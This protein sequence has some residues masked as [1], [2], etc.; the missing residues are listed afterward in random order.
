MKVY[1]NT[2]IEGIAGWVFYDSMSDSRF[3]FNHIQ[4]MNLLLTNEVDAAAKACFDSGAD[5]VYINDSHGCAYNII[6]EHLDPR[7]RII[8]GRSGYFPSWLPLLNESF[9][10][11]IAIGM[12]AMAGSTEAVCTHSCWHVT[13][14]D[15]SRVKLSECAMFAALA[16]EKNV[17]LVMV[18][19]DD[20]IC[21][22]VNKKI[23]GCQTAVVKQGLAAQNA[24]SLMP[25][26]A[27]SL[28]AEKVKAGLAKRKQI[29][30]YKLVGP[31]KLNISDRDPDKR[32]MPEGVRGSDLW[33]LMH[34]VC[35]VFGNKWGDQSIDDRSWRFPDSIYK[36]K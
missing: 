23:P 35:Q 31:F 32:E 17:P 10:A 14:G 33:R 21:A 11:A 1:I 30:P 28:I 7:C 34:G 13:L 22:E 19:G 6:F 20:K 27:C 26:R 5:E 15:G 9:D 16:A 12:H 3:Y 8:H 2:D 29:K 4:R 36:G 18:S 25:A 24:C